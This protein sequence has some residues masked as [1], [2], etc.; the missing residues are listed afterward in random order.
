[1]ANRKEIKFRREGWALTGRQDGVIFTINEDR[2]RN[3]VG[4]VPV[5]PY[6][7]RANDTKGMG[8][9]I[10][11]HGLRY[12]DLDGA[13]EFCQQIM[14][15]EVDLEAMQAEID[16]GQAAKEE[17]AIKAATERAKRFRDKLEAAG[18]SFNTLLDLQAAYDAGMDG[19]AHSILLGWENGEGL[20]N[21]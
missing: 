3:P 17:A 21:V 19:L 6:Y 16:A 10:N 9:S 2:A 1:M 15:G 12:F 18:I 20:P 8:R 7:V 5:P 11:T 13:K 4:A 14:A